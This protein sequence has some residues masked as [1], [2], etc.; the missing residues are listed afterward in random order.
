MYTANIN[1]SVLKG[2]LLHLVER[3]LLTKKIIDTNRKVVGNKFKFKMRGIGSIK[4]YYKTTL[5]GEDLISD[6]GNILARLG[7]LE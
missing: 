7:L 5:K 4:P 2:M 6:Y 3:E 1:C